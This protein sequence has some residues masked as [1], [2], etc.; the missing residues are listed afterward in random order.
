MHRLHTVAASAVVAAMIAMPALASAQSVG[1]V[2]SQIQALM[3]QLRQLQAQL[4]QLKGGATTTMMWHGDSDA[5]STRAMM[6]GDHGMMG[7]GDCPKI[8]R[9]LGR[10]DHDQNTGDVTKLQTFLTSQGYFHDPIDGVF[11]AST[12]TAVKAFQTATGVAIGG[13]PSTNGF[14]AV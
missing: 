1:D 2:Q 3:N 14:G 6:G 11:G 5:S 7:G 10:G 9:A 13:N 8:A 4:I 12:Q